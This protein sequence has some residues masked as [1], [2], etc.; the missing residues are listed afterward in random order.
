MFQDRTE[1]KKSKKKF[2]ELLLKT[3]SPHQRGQL[4]GITKNTEGVN[5]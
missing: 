4:A 3:A 5:L 1:R 2:L